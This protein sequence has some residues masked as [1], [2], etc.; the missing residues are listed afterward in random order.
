[1]S[2][3]LRRAG[4]EE[5][6][7]RRLKHVAVLLA[8]TGIVSS[9]SAEIIFSDVSVT[10]SLSSGYSY[11]TGAYDIDLSFT[12]AIVGEPVD[13]RWEGDLVIS[14]DAENDVP[15]G[16]VSMNLGVLGALSGSGTIIFTE[17]VEDLVTPGVIAT[18]S[19][20]LDENSD[21]PHNAAIEFDRATTKIRVQK[22]LT[23]QAF[24]T[25]ASDLANVSLIEQRLLEV[26]EP[27][28]GVALVAGALSLFRRR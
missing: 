23:L 6:Q 10:G 9:T 28:A 2:P 19:V 15:I 16:L 26:P 13:P 25:D 27:A 5:Q 12:D 14:Y 1:M 18:Y 22:T 4:S 3:R 11:S 24:D 17:T 7:M 8:L 21:L 20:T